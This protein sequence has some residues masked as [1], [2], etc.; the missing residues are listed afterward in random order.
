MFSVCRYCGVHTC[1]EM[2][3]CMHRLPTITLA[4]QG[5]GVVVTTAEKRST[6]AN[7]VRGVMQLWGVHNCMQ[8]CMRLCGVYLLMQL[9][10]C[11]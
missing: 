7:A 1:L 9:S 4:G 10:H 5:L 3:S 2:F 11:L 6:A 8:H